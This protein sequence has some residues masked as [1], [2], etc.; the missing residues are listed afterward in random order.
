[1]GGHGHLPALRFLSWC[2]ENPQQF[3]LSPDWTRAVAV[4]GPKAGDVKVRLCVFST[5]AAGGPDN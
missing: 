4:E 1:M 2:G 3:V 5:P